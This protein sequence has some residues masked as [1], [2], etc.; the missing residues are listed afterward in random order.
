MSPVTTTSDGAVIVYDPQVF[1]KIES[2]FFDPEFWRAQG[3][4]TGSAVGR[5]TAW[6]VRHAGHDLVLRH[7]RRGG[8]LAP[9]LRDRYLWN[10][11]ESTRALRE[12][13]LLDELYRRGFPVPRPIAARV[14]RR[15]LYY[16]ADLMTGRIPTAISLTQ[17]LRGAPLSPEQWQSIGRCVRRFHSAHVHH[18][19]LNANNILLA[20]GRI[21][22]IDFDR[23]RLDA[24]PAQLSRNIARL[25][26]SLDKLARRHADVHFTQ[27]DWSSLLAGYDAT[28]PQ[29]GIHE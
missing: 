27:A 12:W 19:D 4:L 8:L 26:R 17:A 24:A 14:R 22:L 5:G 23:G 28:A 29:H 2:R 20:D 7:F 15:G 1:G 16:R 13:R 11:L 21:Y 9:V 18:A 25:K 10:G 6:F 3:A